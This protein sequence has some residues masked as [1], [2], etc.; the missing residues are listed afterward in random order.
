MPITGPGGYVLPLYT[1]SGWAWL[2]EGSLFG[3]MS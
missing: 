1:G 3:P 2:Q